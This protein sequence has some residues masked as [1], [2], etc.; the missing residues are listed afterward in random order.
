M[1]SNPPDPPGQPTEPPAPGATPPAAD[2]DP[3]PAQPRGVISAVPVGWAGPDAAAPPS[4]PDRPVV[5][6]APPVA[7]PAAATRV[8]EGLVI[9][10]VFSRLVAYAIDT[11]VL[12]ALSVSVNIALGANEPNADATALLIA[13]LVLLLVDAAYFVGLW[14]S[15]WHATLGMRLIGLSVL[16]A[17][18]AAPLRLDAAIIRWL[19]LSG[20][21]RLLALL[22]GL[23]F[24]AWLGLLW[25]IALLVSTSTDRL[26][27]GLHDRLATSVVVQPAP[28]GSGAAVVGCLVLLFLALAGPVAILAVSG[29]AIRE[30]LSRV[31]ES[32]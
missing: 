9:A 28:G 4:S 32:I 7:T 13:N 11:A 17:A 12:L 15:G 6:W 1:S 30:I 21:V 20:I 31:G 16:R 8:G 10:G 26:H 5:D 22:P 29:D 23:G 25:A 3:T 18:D 14:Q 2:P 19:A 27:Q 24:F